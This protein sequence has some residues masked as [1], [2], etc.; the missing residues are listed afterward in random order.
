MD[1]S[2]ILLGIDILA[3]I[4]AGLLDLNCVTCTEEQKYSLCCSG[5]AEM[6]VYLDDNGEFYTCP[7]KFI[8]LQVYE[9]IDEYNYYQMFTGTAPKYNDISNRFWDLAK[10]YKHKLNKYEDEKR[11]HGDK[12]KE[13]DTKSSLNKLRAGFKKK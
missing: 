13:E 9:W 11:N 7:L 8:P 3:K 1:D 10:I 6:P 12:P 2:G 5:N 4:H